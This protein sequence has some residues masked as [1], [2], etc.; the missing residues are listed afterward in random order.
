[1]GGEGRLS[2]CSA[3]DIATRC[4]N[5][6][7]QPITL[8]R[9]R[10]AGSR[11]SPGSAGGAA[12]RA[13]GPR[14]SRKDRLL[15]CTRDAGASRPEASQGSCVVSQI[16]IVHCVSCGTHATAAGSNAVMESAAGRMWSLIVLSRPSITVSQLRSRS[17]CRRQPSPLQ[18]GGPVWP[19]RGEGTALR[20]ALRRCGASQP[21][22]VLL[23]T[24]ASAAGGRQ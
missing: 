12:A 1:M 24:G 10:S 23:T 16:V 5:M 3:R 9:I 11:A 6:L 21:L 20:T 4:P 15:S 8:T 18:Q 17:C 13:A 2:H 7:P 19:G 14:M 22:A